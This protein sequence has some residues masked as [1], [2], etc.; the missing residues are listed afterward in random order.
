VTYPARVMVKGTVLRGE[1]SLLTL[2]CM[3][4]W[5]LKFLSNHLKVLKIS[6]LILGKA[7][8]VS[9]SRSPIS[10]FWSVICFSC[11]LTKSVFSRSDQP[12]Y[13]LH[14]PPREFLASYWLNVLLFPVPNGGGM[15]F[16][17]SENGQFC[18]QCTPMVN[19]W[20]WW[21]WLYQI[22]ALP[23]IQS[24]SCFNEGL[25]VNTS[26]GQVIFKSSG[27]TLSPLLLKEASD[28]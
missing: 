27:V 10:S 19:G 5:P 8:T 16:R 17:F 6:M 12:E 3:S 18:T 11:P 1:K 4:I 9:T 15:N 2:P 22:A 21:C 26:G 28:F 7:P 24:Q 20:I 23:A 14:H 13:I 25:N